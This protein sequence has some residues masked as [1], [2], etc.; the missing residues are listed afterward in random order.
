[1]GLMGNQWTEA[2]YGAHYTKA[3][4]VGEGREA[5]TTVG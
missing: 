3:P 5:D 2:A 1:M 4:D